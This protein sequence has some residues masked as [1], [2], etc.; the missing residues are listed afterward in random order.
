M[1]SGYL[2]VTIAL[3]LVLSFSVSLTGCGGGGGSELAG[4]K[5]SMSFA[6]NFPPL[7]KSNSKVLPSVLMSVVI[8]I[9]DADKA[10]NLLPRL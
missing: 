4:P 1:K 8:D 2:G 9:L 5:G 6:V 7:P 10:G 3:L